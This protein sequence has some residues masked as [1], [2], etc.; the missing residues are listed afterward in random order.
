MNEPTALVLVDLQT[1][2]FGG[3]GIPAMH[4]ADRVLANTVALLHDARKSGV[5]VVHIQHCGDAGTAFGEDA[6][7]WR[8]L[9]AV[10]PLNDEVVVRKRTRNAFDGTDLDQVLRRLGVRRIIVAGLQS[11]LCVAATCRGALK[12]G[13]EVRLA[14]DGHSTWPDRTRSADEIIAGENEALAAEGVVLR[15]TATLIE[16]LGH[17]GARGSDAALR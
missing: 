14:Q 15:T 12:L 4:D 11:E 13:Y 5:P 10:S 17:L 2:A 16:G 8:I 3:A 9:P 1:A 7:G 6:P